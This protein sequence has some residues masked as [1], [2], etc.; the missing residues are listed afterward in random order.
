MQEKLIIFVQPLLVMRSIL[1]KNG[2]IFQQYDLKVSVFQKDERYIKST[3]LS[4]IQL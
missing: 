4:F 2:L 3:L 1:M